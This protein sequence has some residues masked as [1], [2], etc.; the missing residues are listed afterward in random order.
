MARPRVLLAFHSYEGQSA[1]IGDR[2][3]TVL[4]AA[5]IGVDVLD[6]NDAPPPAGYDGVVL[7]DSIHLM[8][9]SLSLKRY[10]TRHAYELNALPL[11]LFQVSLTSANH[12]AAHAARAHELAQD[13]VVETGIDPDL[14]GLFAGSLA[15]TKYG[16][17]KRRMMR[18][19]LEQELGESDISTDHEYT[20]WDAVSE[21]A[22]DV[23]A[24][25]NQAASP[26][27]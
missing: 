19:I 3:A 7:G 11:A 13:F 24:T 26:A 27:E 1:K 10:A 15:F 5:G 17:M 14:V 9:H 21:F 18:R 16:W 25:V 4:E 12:D 2:I 22:L 20:D 8:E 6:A 23:A